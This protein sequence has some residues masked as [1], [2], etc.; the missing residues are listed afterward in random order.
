MGSYCLHTQW[1]NESFSTKAA[2]PPPPSCNDA[3]AIVS[4]CRFPFSSAAPI[5]KS[6][7]SRHHW[8][9]PRS[10]CRL[11]RKL[12]LFRRRLCNLNNCYRSC[13]IRIKIHAGPSCT[14][15]LIRCGSQQISTAMY[16]LLFIKLQYIFKDS[17]IQGQS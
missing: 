17:K 10:C 5:R 15:S 7:S 4:V 8:C 6:S 16:M 9:L 1:K 2:P 12:R 11:R 3:I 13:N 14:S